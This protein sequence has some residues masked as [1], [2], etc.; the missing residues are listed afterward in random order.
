ME[1]GI[2]PA[3]LGAYP[4]APVADRIPDQSTETR[5]GS[6]RTSERGSVLALLNLALAAEIAC[7]LRYRRHRLAAIRSNEA[8]A[9]ADYAALAAENQLHAG[10]L[11]ERSVHLGREPGFA[12][13]RI[14]RAV[15]AGTARAA[16]ARGARLPPPR[17]PLPSDVRRRLHHVPL[18]AAH[19][20]GTGARLQPRRRLGAGARND[21]TALR[22]SPGRVRAPRS[23]SRRRSARTEPS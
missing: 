11:A 3:Y 6:G 7:M 15:H 4:V 10:R 2:G 20:R 17:G 22:A 19:G 23:G 14:R 18:R 8:A 21:H 9:A 5:A 16:R 1:L 13:R 12:T